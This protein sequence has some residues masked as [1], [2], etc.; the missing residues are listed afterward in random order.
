MFDTKA[1]YYI[2]CYLDNRK[3]EARVNGTWQEIIV[4]LPKGSILLQI[5]LND[6][7]NDHFYCYL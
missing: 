2:K 3:Q 4:G 5:L 1:L 7:V 6:F